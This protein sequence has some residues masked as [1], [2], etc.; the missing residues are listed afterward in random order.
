MLR[1]IGGNNGWD[2]NLVF[3]TREYEAVYTDGPQGYLGAFYRSTESGVRWYR[4]L[5]PFSFGIYS[6]F[7][8]LAYGLSWRS[9]GSLVLSFGEVFN[10]WVASIVYI[11]SPGLCAGLCRP[12]FLFDIW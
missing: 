11:R 5:V 7:V 8:E 4:F 12:S 9:A 10:I 6:L 1:I 2:G 3:D